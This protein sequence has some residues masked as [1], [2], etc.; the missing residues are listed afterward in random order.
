MMRPMPTLAIESPCVGNC[1]LNDE[2]ICLGCGRSL[3]EIR[4]W[5]LVDDERRKIIVRNAE[6]RRR[7]SDNP[8]KQP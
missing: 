7:S 2:L 3:D 4:E 1:C 8:D 5:T 6:A